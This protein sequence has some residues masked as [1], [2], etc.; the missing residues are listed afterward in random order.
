MRQPES[1]DVQSGQGKQEERHHQEHGATEA[2]ALAVGFG[3]V[4]LQMRRNTAKLFP[5]FV[6]RA[7]RMIRNPAFVRI[8]RFQSQSFSR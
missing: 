8:A 5:G 2:F 3:Q 1:T 6:E 7:N 4:V